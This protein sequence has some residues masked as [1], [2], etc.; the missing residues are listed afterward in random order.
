M[1]VDKI[2]GQYQSLGSRRWGGRAVRDGW[3]EAAA[4]MPGRAWRGLC[5]WCSLAPAQGLFPP[6][7]S[8]PCCPY[9]GQG[10]VLG[11]A[12]RRQTMRAELWVSGQSRP[13]G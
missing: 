3:A 9:A 13:A 10:R 2:E 8:Q 1:R 7:P 4:L 5:T 6:H 11:E 12:G